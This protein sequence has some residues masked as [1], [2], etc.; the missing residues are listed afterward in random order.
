V[1]F[2][3]NHFHLWYFGQQQHV[4]HCENFSNFVIAI[5]A[6]WIY[7]QWQFPVSKKMQKPFKNSANLLLFI[8]L[9]TEIK[10]WNKIK[11]YHVPCPVVASI[12]QIIQ[13]NTKLFW[14]IHVQ[15]WFWAMIQQWFCKPIRCFISLVSAAS[16]LDPIL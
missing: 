11:I 7:Q 12:I 13:N 3:L 9:C 1:L 2:Q 6:I 16:C 10:K 4:A 15:Q 8:T 14:S 5:F